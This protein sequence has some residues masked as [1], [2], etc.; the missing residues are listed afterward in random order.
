MAIDTARVKS[1]FLAASDLADPPERAAYLDRECGREAALRARVEALLRAND[2]SPLPEPGL[3]DAT[4]AFAPDAPAAGATTDH[5]G[6]DEQAGTVIAGKYTLVEVIGEGGMGSVWRARQTEPVKR[7]VAVKLIKAGM[8][9]RQVLA[10]FDAERQA[11]ALMDH[12]NIAKVLDGGLHESR[13]YFVMELVK[14]VPITDYCDRCRLTPKE[15][16]ELFVPVCQAIQH[17]HQKGIIH[18]DIKPSNVLIALYDDRPMVKVIDFGVAKATGGALT[19]HTIDTVFGGVVGTP[20]YMSPEQATFNNLDIDTRSDVYALGVLL[21]ELLTGSPPF[22]MKELEKKGLPEILRVVREEEPP[23]P[24]NKLSTADALPTLSANRGTDPK[25]LTGLLRNELDWVVM[26]ALEKDRTRRYESANGFAADVLRYLCGEAVQ[27]HP[28]STAYRL[29]KFVRRNKGP[30]G[31]AAVVFLALV[32]GMIG[33]GVGLATANRALVGEQEANHHLDREKKEADRLRLEA[34]ASERQV[35][36]ALEGQRQATRVAVSRQLAA[37]A[38]TFRDDRFDRALLLAAEACR[39]EPTFEAR[40]TLLACLQSQPHLEKFLHGHRSVVSMAYSPDGRV[41]ATGGVSEAREQGAIRLWEAATGTP[42]GALAGMPSADLR[43]IAFGPDSSLLAAGHSD[44]SVLL[45][46]TRTRQRLGPALK[47]GGKDA[48]CL[49]FSPDGRLLACGGIGRREIEGTNRGAITVW[50]LRS[51]KPIHGGMRGHF[52]P[53]RCLAF[54]PDSRTL[55]SGN[56]GR[57]SWRS[58]RDYDVRLWDVATGQPRGAPMGAGMQWVTALA[59]RPDGASLVAG[60]GDGKVGQWATTDQKAKGQQ[61]K[62]PFK[63]DNNWLGEGRRSHDAP[64]LSIAYSRDG[65]AFVSGDG[66]NKLIVWGADGQPRG[67]IIG[68][69]Q[70]VSSLVIHPDLLSWAVAS[71]AVVTPAR[72]CVRADVTLWNRTITPVCG[73]SV[74]LPGR[75]F[76]S[77][78][79]APDGRLAA[80]STELNAPESERYVIFLWDLA[81]RRPVRG[82]LRG[83]EAWVVDLAFSPGGGVLASLDIDGAVLLWDAQAGKQLGRPFA[84]TGRIKCLAFSP[85][86]KRLLGGRGDDILIWDVAANKPAGAP[87]RAKVGVVNAVVLTPDG[88]HLIAGGGEYDDGSAVRFPPTPKVKGAVQFFDGRSYAPLG[89]PVEAHT[90][91]LASLAVSPDGRVLASGGGH[92][93]GTILLWDVATRRPVGPPLIGQMTCVK[94]LA[95]SPDGAVL[96]SAP[97]YYRD[98]NR[99]PL[100]WDVAAGGVLLRLTCPE[101]GGGGPNAFLDGLVFNPRDSSLL[102]AGS[103]REGRYFYYAGAMQAWIARARAIANRDLEPGER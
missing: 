12:P 70:R 28:P 92:H 39:L 53:V 19:E 6:K 83:H 25:R 85:D 68:L 5:P 46:D 44:G 29:R 31:A 20:Q 81:A 3:A 101:P 23:R 58:G 38:L 95:F 9:S 100:L 51:G 37:E 24:S 94:R 87:V 79:I 22:S 42:L 30:V 52:S 34:E 80:V 71:E 49:S 26:K 82:P 60:F 99:P 55:A 18:R 47:A 2:A 84:G 72:E 90:D 97:H 78:A 4:G 15:R 14:G 89:D 27:A 54:S 36:L 77:A 64:V 86:G 21:Y 32:A 41:L 10:R 88:K 69:G 73:E 1:L 40:R 98:R 63:L 45:W 59:F 50:E 74:T 75:G 48:F 67:Q 33:T 57:L 96:A 11:L 76:S 66:S 93:D 13:P 62:A 102:I 43:C 16:L 91:G 61:G 7:F 17:A 56:G 65:A 35:R 8:D 103:Y